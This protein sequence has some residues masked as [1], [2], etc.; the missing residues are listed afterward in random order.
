MSAEFLVSRY[1]GPAGADD[2]GKPPRTLSDKLGP[3][4]QVLDQLY[5]RGQF[6][7]PA[8]KTVEEMSGIL[9]KRIKFAQ[10]TG[11]MRKPD[12]DK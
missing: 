12:D 1:C 10:D 3:A 7:P 2:S 8:G 4:K 6:M 11:R 9:E 5:A